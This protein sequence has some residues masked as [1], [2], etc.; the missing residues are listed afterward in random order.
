MAELSDILAARGEMK[1]AASLVD[2]A[3]NLAPDNS[4]VLSAHARLLAQSLE[5]EA[6]DKVL[7]QAI[8]ADPDWAPL[9]RQ[10]AQV[11]EKLGDEAEAMSLRTKAGG[12]AMGRIF[13]R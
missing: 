8:E 2:A 3:L 4:V 5:F 12:A 11:Q 6:A 13:L 9:Y 7:L 10:R 1:E